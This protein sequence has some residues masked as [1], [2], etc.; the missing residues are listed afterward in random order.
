[1]DLRHLQNL[2]YLADELHFGRAAKRAHLS[3]SAFTRSIQALEDEIGLTLFDRNK[4]VVRITPVG[5]S[6]AERART[7]LAG[8]RNLERELEHIRTGGMGSVAIGG[9]P[10]SSGFLVLPALAE[11]Q[12]A[13]PG[14]SARL[15]IYDAGR[16]LEHL[17]DERIDLLVGDM[18]YLTSSKEFSVHALGEFAGQLYCRSAHPLTRK[19][20]VK[21]AD[22]RPYSLA[23]VKLPPTFVER[24]RGALGL[25]QNDGFNVGFEC[26]CVGT[27]VEMSRNTDMILMGTDCAVQHLIE[28]GEMQRLE[29]DGFDRTKGLSSAYGMVRMAGR[30][31]SPSAEVLCNL[32][33]KHNRDPAA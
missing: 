26:S 22:L 15:E 19:R 24:M 14:V 12:R 29:I 32:L 17:K 30:T 2:A 16:G 33:L 6:T 9:G 8:A 21:P 31:L 20:K 27:L 1:V 28:R 23:S 10:F 25:G 18:R 11:L 13:H 5:K 3:Q 4:R 7:L